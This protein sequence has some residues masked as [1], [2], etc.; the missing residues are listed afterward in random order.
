[1]LPDRR[2]WRLSRQVSNVAV[3]LCAAVAVLGVCA[4]GLGTLP[5]LGPLLDP[6]HG[7]WAAASGGQPPVSQTL[8]LP[9]LV[10]PVTVS[11]DDA[12]LPAI[13]AADRTDSALALGY[14]H[15]RFRLTQLDLLRRR[16]EG[17]L[18][19][20]VGP[21]G[22]ASDTLELRLGLL[23]TARQEWAR[24]PAR[25][26]T[27]ELLTA[28][29]HGVNDYL[30]QVRADRQWPALF[31][32]AGVY[33]AD[34]TPVD[35]LAV[36]GELT[37]Q[38]DFTTTPLDYAVL[39][40]SL[41]MARTM[42]W[43]PVSFGTGAGQH[44]YDPG[45]YHASGVARIAK[46]MTAGN[47]GAVPSAAVAR[48]AAAILAQTSALAS[49]PAEGYSTG[50]AWVA[51]GPKV[52]GGRSVLAEDAYLPHTWPSVWFEVAISAPGFDVTGATVPGIP[53]VL[54]GHNRHIAWSLTDTANQAA[55]FYAER[56]SS[57]RP[58]RYLWRGRWRPMRRVRYT[59]AVR[60]APA[61]HLTVLLT[62]HGPVLSQAGPAVSVDWMGS[63]PSP[64]ISVLAAIGAARDFGQFRAAL[65]SWRAPAQD[66]L[67][68]D[69]RGNIAAISAGYYPLVRHGRPWLPMPGTGADDVAG[70]IPFAALPHS[71]DPPDHVIVTAGQR[72]VS[73]SYPYYIGTTA[74][75]FGPGCRVSQEYSF[76]A[77]RSR[78]R[79]SGLSVPQTSLA[80]QFA[81]RLVPRLVAA[82]RPARLGPVQHEALALLR[83][84]DHSMDPGSAAAAIWS[85]F[86][87]AYVDATFAPWWQAAKVP[88]RWDPAVLTVS[89]SQLTLD[90]VLAHWTLADRS[91]AAFS[92]P[93]EAARTAVPVLRAAFKTAVASLRA[94][95]GGSP[96]GWML[97]RLHPSQSPVLADRAV[98][99]LADRTVS[100]WQAADGYETPDDTA[101]CVPVGRQEPGWRMIVRWTG[102]GAAGGVMAE[103]AY[104]GGQNE[105][106]ASPWYANLI[107]D[108]QN[109]LY[110]PMPA[111]GTV[112][113]VRASGSSGVG[114]AAGSG[115]PWWELRP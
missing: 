42:S 97:R 102:A 68:A 104:P 72:P 69:D 113:L 108:W 20:L 28:Y 107:A 35:S 23:R 31:S 61:R 47:A 12:G 45:P 6:G 115:S 38:L 44:P 95:L 10:A 70:V 32:V 109:G 13:G 86:W 57:T 37:Q 64:D 33:P 29:A 74:N 30:D 85:T 21:A 9:G 73:A 89:A 63:L 71:Y 110:L 81:A 54:A 48:A 2:R 96:A 3:A 66:F 5:A 114:G 83:G 43:F 88:V 75:Q 111:V 67:Y 16:A 15:A 80:D 87:A 98:S 90:Q 51:N 46:T 17:R 112:G 25:S 91:N 59:I 65:R 1:M 40:R 49:G 7:A 82:L 24:L 105:N 100:G 27:A 101:S 14:L 77:A 41:G 53:G 93:G 39:A 52:A 36:Q 94:R 34:W 55:L 56:T 84:W 8:T 62:V 60:G 78:L 79:L 58:G 92:A 103:G 22:L 106:P 26:Q 4:A 99:G 19:A 18:S 76:L 50:G 11:F